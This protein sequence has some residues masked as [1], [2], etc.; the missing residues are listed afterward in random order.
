ML[1]L[2]T[3]LD[4][5]RSVQA[6]T[7]SQLCSCTA[8]QQISA[9]TEYSD[10]HSSLSCRKAALWLVGRHMPVTST[11]VPD[12]HPT[13]KSDMQFLSNFACGCRSTQP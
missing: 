10:L 8:H 3:Q 9:Q 7:V 13:C 12:I 1:S 6:P 11:S 2:W 5:Y 4:A